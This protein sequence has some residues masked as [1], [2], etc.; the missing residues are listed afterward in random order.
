VFEASHQGIGQRARSL[1]T[2]FARP[3]MPYAKDNQQLLAACSGLLRDSLRW[4]G[5]ATVETDPATATTKVDPETGEI[6]SP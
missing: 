5:V 3:A 6:T 4:R 2:Y 1:E